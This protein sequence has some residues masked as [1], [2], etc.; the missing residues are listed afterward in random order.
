MISFIARIVLFLLVVWGIIKLVEVLRPRA[1]SFT[2]M[3]EYPNK[4]QIALVEEGELISLWAEPKTQ[5]VY[6]YRSGSSG[7]EGYLGQLPGK[8]YRSIEPVL[9]SGD[10][11]QAFVTEHTGGNIRLEVR[12]GKQQIP[13][14]FV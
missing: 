9:R 5:H 14:E 6:A 4:R 2:T 11:Y 1:K 3:L 8:Y 10:T 12:L 13:D 7:D